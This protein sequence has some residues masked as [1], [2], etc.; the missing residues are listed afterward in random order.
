MN[1]IV[2]CESEVGEEEMEE[3]AREVTR[4]VERV[5]KAKGGKGN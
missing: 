2:N 3:R 4:E 1:E 5:K